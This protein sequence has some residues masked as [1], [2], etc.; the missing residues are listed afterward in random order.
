M[1]YK[2]NPT[3]ISRSIWGFLAVW[4][5][6]AVIHIVLITL[7]GGV[8]II[9]SS[10]VDAKIISFEDIAIIGVHCGLAHWVLYLVF[11]FQLSLVA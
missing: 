5:Y 4:I 6:V 7:G 2:K 9:W 3:F 1:Q 11:H 10:F 8:I